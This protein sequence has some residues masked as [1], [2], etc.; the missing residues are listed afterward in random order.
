MTC[1]GI[2]IKRELS[3]ALRQRL[4]DMSKAESYAYYSAPCGA[5]MPP[6]TKLVKRNLRERRM[7]VSVL[8]DMYAAPNTPNFLG[9]DPSN[10]DSRLICY[11]TK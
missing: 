11:S 8:Q 10:T 2:V 1:G 6:K 4:T 5:R 9:V 7:I 3:K